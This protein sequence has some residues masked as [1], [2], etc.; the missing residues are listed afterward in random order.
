MIAGS[1]LAFCSCDDDESPEVMDSDRNFLINATFANRAEADLGQLAINRSDNAEVHDF[2][3][4][5]ATD[6]STSLNEVTE[7]ADQKDVE[8][9]QSL[10]NEHEQLK[11]R[12]SGLSG[13]AFDTVYINSQ[14]KDH[15]NVIAMFEEQSTTTQDSGIKAYVEKTL[16]HLNEHLA[17]AKIVQAHLMQQ[18]SGRKRSD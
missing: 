1:V 6:H 3:Q 7:I 5:M 14:V 11:Q 9:P 15:E 8:V 2:A 16:P 18:A 17:N 13:M 12:L 4:Q 10:D